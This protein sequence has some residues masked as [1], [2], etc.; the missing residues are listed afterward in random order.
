MFFAVGMKDIIFLKILSLLL[1]CHLNMFVDKGMLFVSNF[2][3]QNGLIMVV[4]IR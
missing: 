1:I 2:W 3:D 4:H